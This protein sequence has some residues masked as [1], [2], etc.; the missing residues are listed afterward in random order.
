MF[1]VYCRYQNSWKASPEILD[2]KL[3]NTGM[4]AREVQFMVFLYPPP[5]QKKKAVQIVQKS[6]KKTSDKLFVRFH[7]ITSA[8]VV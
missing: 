3:D 1:V 7:I 4:N 2:L 6:A 5:P 8:S